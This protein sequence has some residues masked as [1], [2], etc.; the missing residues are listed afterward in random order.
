MSLISMAVKAG[1]WYLA[2]HLIQVMVIVEMQ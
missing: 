1:S 2:L